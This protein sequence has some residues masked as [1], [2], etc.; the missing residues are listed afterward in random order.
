[1]VQ[2]EQALIDAP[3]TAVWELVGNPRRYPEWWPRWI[4]IRGERFEEG[5]EFLQVSRTP[6]GRSQ[7]VFMIDRLDELRQIRMHCTQSGTF[8]DWRLTDAQGGT[9]VEISAGIEPLRAVDRLFDRT[10][11]R[12]FFRRWATEA[13]GALER[14][15]AR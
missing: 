15:T 9:F 5:T 12:Q 7:S 13:V 10:F 4:E 2:R 14:A 6:I 8:A 3:V 1:M 11:A